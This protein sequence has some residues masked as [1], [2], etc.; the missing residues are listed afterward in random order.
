ML[1]VVTSTLWLNFG[2]QLS[3]KQH[4]HDAKTTRFSYSKTRNAC[5]VSPQNKYSGLIH[6]NPKLSL[7]EGDGLIVEM[8]HLWIR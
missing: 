7:S 2:L 4:G 6:A 3:N 5:R 8:A 1:A